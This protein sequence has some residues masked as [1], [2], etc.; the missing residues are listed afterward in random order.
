MRVLT[1]KY[2]KMNRKF[3]RF[4]LRNIAVHFPKNK[5]IEYY[6]YLI[7]EQ[8]VNAKHIICNLVNSQCSSWRKLHF[9]QVCKV[10]HS[11]YFT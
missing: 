1:T 9:L 4:V 3:L 11:S 5:Y 10:F 2:L 6:I 7:L 8:Y